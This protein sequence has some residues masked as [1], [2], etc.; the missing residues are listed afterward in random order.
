MGRGWGGGT[1]KDIFRSGQSR[2]TT[3]VR[4]SGLSVNLVVA[5][6]GDQQQ[7][8]IISE[9]TKVSQMNVKLVKGK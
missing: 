3:R 8:S 7:I 1:E 6:T 9:G 5:T 4:G 2:N